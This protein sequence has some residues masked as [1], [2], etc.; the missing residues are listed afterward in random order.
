ML[1]LFERTYR[2]QSVYSHYSRTYFFVHSP[3]PIAHPDHILILCLDMFFCFYHPAVLEEMGTED[4]SSKMIVGK[5][6]LG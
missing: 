6:E 5:D 2:L 1:S 4:N 3:S